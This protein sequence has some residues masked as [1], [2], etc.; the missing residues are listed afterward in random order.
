LGTGHQLTTALAQ[1]PLHYSVFE[2]MLTLFERWA[3][4]VIGLSPFGVVVLAHSIRSNNI[5]TNSR[6]LEFK[7][8]W[9][10]IGLVVRVTI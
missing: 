3:A 6:P 10:Y 7:H 1:L 8:D 9:Y 4:H 5:S 2:A